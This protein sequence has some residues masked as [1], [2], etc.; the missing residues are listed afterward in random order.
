MTEVVIRV[1][2][3]GTTTVKV[4]GHQG[5]DCSLVSA[6]YRH[7]LGVSLSETPTAEMFE[8]STTEQHEQIHTGERRA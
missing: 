6:P 5:P 3:D 1:A 8:T 7:A 4:E 2:K